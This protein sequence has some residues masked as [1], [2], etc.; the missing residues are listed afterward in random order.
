MN[1]MLA[2]LFVCIALGLLAPRLGRREQLILGFLATMTTALY[3]F[4]SARFM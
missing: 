1:L 4:L 2:F 3:F